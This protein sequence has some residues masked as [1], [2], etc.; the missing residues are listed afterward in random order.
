MITLSLRGAKKAIAAMLR[1]ERPVVLMGSPGIG[2]TE[3]FKQA[4]IEAGI[5]CKIF[6]ASSLDPTDTRG[7]LYIVGDQAKYSR[8][9]IL[10]EKED[11]EKGILVIDELAS[12]L[13]ATQV[14]LYPL[15]RER[16]LGD[17]HLNDGWLPMGTGNYTTDGAVAYNL[18]TALSDRV[19]MINVEPSF[20]VWKEDFAL[21]KKLD[22]TIIGFLNF[23]SD[24]F[25]T[26]DK[27]E[28][29]AKG[30]SF[31]SPRSYEMASDVLQAGLDDHTLLAVL[32]G[33]LGDGVATELMAFRQ[34]Y[35]DLPDINAIYQ[36]KYGEIP[37]EP[38]I[39]YA[40]SGALTGYLNNLPK[41]MSLGD[42]TARLLDYTQKLP[43]E[44]AVLTIKDGMQI[45]PNHKKSF[46][47][48]KNWVE[49]GQK[50]KEVVL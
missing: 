21:P 31:A 25:Y 2:K 35:S 41:K 5:K 24:L 6:E 43:A 13:P 18:S 12:C 26:F 42:A 10:P 37:V 48:A 27:R 34:V 8:P 11:G 28:K 49:W 44:F 32:A 39:L 47:Q 36:G 17:F 50:Y 7:L 45:S 29:N 19:I 30:K 15:F 22:P 38:S 1:K 3:I 23:R 33:T 40:L 9:A 46:I 16:R 14:S 4:A 20:Q